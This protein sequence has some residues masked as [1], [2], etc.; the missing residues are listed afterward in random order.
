MMQQRPGMPTMRPPGNLSSPPTPCSLTLPLT[1]A[2]TLPLTIAL[3]LPCDHALRYTCF[4]PIPLVSILQH[5]NSTV[6][7]LCAGAPPG[8]PQGPQGPGM[9]QMRPPGATAAGNTAVLSPPISY[10]Y[11]TNSSPRHHTYLSTQ[12][13]PQDLDQE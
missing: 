3:T 10:V 7:L 11:L 12:V 8:A 2:L 9:M 4:S 13:G 6:F 1:I 5:S